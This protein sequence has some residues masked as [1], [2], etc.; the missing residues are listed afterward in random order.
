MTV[1][2]DAIPIGPIFA[3]HGSIIRLHAIRIGSIFAPHGSIIEPLQ[4]APSGTVT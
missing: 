4:I 1:P 2:H 3:P